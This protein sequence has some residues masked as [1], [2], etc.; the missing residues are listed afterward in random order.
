MLVEMEDVALRENPVYTIAVHAGEEPDAY[1]GS[2]SVP[3]YNSAVFAFADA[4][5]GAAIN[6]GEQPGYAYGRKGNPTQTALEKA[7]CEL[8]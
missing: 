5:Q 8:E 4:E 3:V 2:L 1:L 6:A 7:L